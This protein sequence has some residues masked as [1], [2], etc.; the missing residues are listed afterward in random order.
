MREDEIFNKI[1]EFIVTERWNYDFP[2][3]RTTRLYEDL[4]IYGT[5]A[6]NFIIKFGKVFNV[7]VSRFKAADYFKGEGDSLIESILNSSR[8]KRDKTELKK[9]TIGD[10]EKAVLKGKLDD[11]VINS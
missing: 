11:D 10:L 2:L 9:L 8:K 3:N 5:D 4:R 6:V 7:D 1:Q